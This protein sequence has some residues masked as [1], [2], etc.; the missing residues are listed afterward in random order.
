M[1]KQYQKQKQRWIQKGI[2]LGLEL[3]NIQKINNI[4]IKYI[5]YGIGN[6]IDDTV[7]IHKAFKKRPDLLKKILDH[8][9]KHINKEKYVDWKEPFHL[10]IFA[11]TLSHPTMWLHYLPIWITKENKK[12]IIAVN[13][14]YTALWGFIVSWFLLFYLSIKFGMVG[15]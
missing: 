14:R 15:L 12:F 5:D 3:S 10:D 11:F 8:E 2:D 6:V 9:I 7:Y 4:K 13:Y 1:S